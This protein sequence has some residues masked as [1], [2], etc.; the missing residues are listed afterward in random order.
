MVYL[1][2]I[3]YLIIYVLSS[4]KFKYSSPSG[5]FNYIYKVNNT[6]YAYFDS[7]NVYIEDFNNESKI[8]QFYEIL[9]C[10]FGAITF[11]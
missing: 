11:F 9:V 3:L 10:I 6:S 5:I 2:K 8:N 4:F 1:G 7:I